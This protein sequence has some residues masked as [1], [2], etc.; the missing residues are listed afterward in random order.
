MRQMMD[1]LRKS[2]LVTG[3]ITTMACLTVAAIGVTPAQYRLVHAKDGVC[4]SF[5]ESKTIRQ[6]VNPRNAPRTADSY[7]RT[8]TLSKDQAKISNKALLA[9]F[10]RGFF[11]S[12]V[13]APEAFALRL[14]RLDLGEFSGMYIC[15]SLCC[16]A[17]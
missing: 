17:L 13:F 7:F 8:I 12:R 9:N 5:S 6:I 15:R 10:L 4:K 14:L 2:A 11:S 16:C 1:I 3:A